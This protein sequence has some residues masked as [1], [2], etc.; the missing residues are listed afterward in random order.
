MLLNTCPAVIST[1]RGVPSGLGSLIRNPVPTMRLPSACGWSI[2]TVALIM[3]VVRSMAKP[4]PRRSNNAAVLDRTN[5]AESGPLSAPG[6]EA[7]LRESTGR[8]HAKPDQPTAPV[9]PRRPKRI[10]QLGRTRVDDYA[11]MKDENWRKV[12][13]DP[14]A[15]DPDI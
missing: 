7:A 5:G 2:S 6:Q 14:S 1:V 8:M 3:A 11:W 12:L 9:A 13:H 10:E 4:G 15:L